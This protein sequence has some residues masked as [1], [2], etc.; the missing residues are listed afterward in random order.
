MTIYFDGIIL[1]AIIYTAVRERCIKWL[2]E[3]ENGLWVYKE[4]RRDSKLIWFGS[5]AAVSREFEG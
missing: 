1:E 2:I 4:L 3:G 5:I